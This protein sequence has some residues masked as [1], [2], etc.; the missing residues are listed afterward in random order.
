M[1]L[2]AC[3]VQFFFKFD[4]NFLFCYFYDTVSHIETFGQINCVKM[5]IQM[6]QINCENQPV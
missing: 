6:N 1:Y 4:S 2:F 3:E 5:L